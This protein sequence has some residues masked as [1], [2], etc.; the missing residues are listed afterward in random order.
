MLFGV[1]FVIGHFIL[2]HVTSC[3]F[4]SF[5]VISAHLVSFYVSKCHITSYHVSLDFS[6]HHSIKSGQG[7]G[8]G[9]VF[10]GLR[11]QLCC[12]TEGKNYLFQHGGNASWSKPS[13][14]GR[15][16]A[17]AE[18]VID[19]QISFCMAGMS[20]SQNRSKTPVSACLEYVVLKN[21][22]MAET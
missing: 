4:M 14:L 20:Y 2:F 8:R 6:D 9:R 5:H 18:C 19:Q 16:L 21:V 1:N 22:S 10:L 3:H 13:V 12:Q 7:E 11:R 17:L 15:F